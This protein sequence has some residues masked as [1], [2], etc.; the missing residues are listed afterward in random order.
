MKEEPFKQSEIRIMW[1]Q[2]PCSNA[3][4]Q[5]LFYLGSSGAIHIS[6]A[7]MAKWS[8]VDKALANARS[9]KNGLPQGRHDPLGPHNTTNTD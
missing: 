6:D 3:Q 8:D 5:G 4:V 1:N 2:P 9:I 7:V